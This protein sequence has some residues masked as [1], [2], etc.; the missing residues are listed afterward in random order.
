MGSGAIIA[1]AHNWGEV[2]HIVGSKGTLLVDGD[3][4]KI[5][6]VNGKAEDVVLPKQESTHITTNWVD[7]IFGKAKLLSPAEA[8]VEVIRL[9]EAIWKSAA[10]GGKPVRIRSAS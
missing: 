3:L 9:T 2:W 1:T 8:G 10:A 7:A 4:K 6:E 5:S